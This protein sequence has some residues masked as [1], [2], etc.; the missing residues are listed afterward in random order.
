MSTPPHSVRT[1]SPLQQIMNASSLDT[2]CSMESNAASALHP[3]STINEKLFSSVSASPATE[4]S[5]V[6]I[7]QSTSPLTIRRSLQSSSLASSLWN[8][9]NTQQDE[10]DQ[11]QPVYSSSVYTVVDDI[12]SMGKTATN[13]TLSQSMS[14]TTMNTIVNAANHT[15]TNI[16]DS[17]GSNSSKK[18]VKFASPLVSALKKTNNKVYRPLTPIP[19][20]LQSKRSQYVDEPVEVIQRSISWKEIV[21]SLLL[22]I[23]TI[24]GVILCKTTVIS[25]GFKT[26]ITG[27]SANYL[28]QEQQQQQHT[29]SIQPDIV[30]VGESNL[31]TS[32]NQP[33]AD[34]KE[35]EI[36]IPP[37]WGLNHNDNNKFLTTSWTPLEAFSSNQPDT[38]P[39]S[40]SK[41]VQFFADQSSHISPEDRDLL[42][43]PQ[44]CLTWSSV[45][46]STDPTSQSHQVQSLTKSFAFLLKPFQV[47]FRWVKSAVQNTKFLF[48]KASTTKEPHDSPSSIKAGFIALENCHSKLNR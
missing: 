20:K 8:A 19:Y 30:K 37:V 47:I 22:T 2:P 1:N 29:Q 46:M 5:T 15:S 35:G 27:S 42:L 9:T 17:S 44:Q 24:L 39:M 4:S 23:V 11:I 16:D 13:N 10:V 36:V 38:L 7:V 3:A 26:S 6:R 34:I 18:E 48:S 21:I 28:N 32:N 43:L 41:V 14:S 33:S 12:V 25:T 40:K 31:I 45:S